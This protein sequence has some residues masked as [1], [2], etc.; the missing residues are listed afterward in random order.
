MAIPS[1][2]E[3]LTWG[4]IDTAT[5]TGGTIYHKHEIAIVLNAGTAVLQGRRSGSTDATDWIPIYTWTADL[6]YPLDHIGAMDLR[7][8]RTGATEGW[9]AW[10]DDRSYQT[11]AP[12]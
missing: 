9:H 11:G 2:Q 12:G 5:L 4:G 7:V 3:D 10:A 1:Y 8:I 6:V